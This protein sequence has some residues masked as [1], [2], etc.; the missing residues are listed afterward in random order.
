[1]KYSLPLLSLLLAGLGGA[2]S[3]APAQSSRAQLQDHY[4]VQLRRDADPLRAAQRHGVG[5]TFLYSR[6]INGFA[7]KIPPGILR[8][9]QRDPQVIA[10]IPDRFISAIGF[11]AGKPGGGGSGTTGQVVPPGITRVGAA[12]ANNLGFTG[13]GIGVAIVDT[14]IDL[15]HPDLRIS[16]V[17]FSA[18][19]GSATDD[20]GHGTHVAGTVGALNNNIGVVGVAPGVTLYSVK[21]VDYLTESADSLILA[22]L[23]WLASNAAT[24]SPPIR[25]VNM[26]IARNGSVSDNP[27]LHAAVQT[28]VNQGITIVVAAGNESTMTVS[29]QIPAT[30]PEVLAIASTTAS[31][32]PRNKKT[33]L[34]VPRDSASFFT[35]DGALDPFTGIGVTV[36]APGNEQETISNTGTF[37]SLGVL[38]TAWSGWGGNTDRISGTSMASP[39][40]AGVVALLWEQALARGT[41]LAP[42]DARRRIRAGAQL[43]NT[44]PLN[45]LSSTYT[46]DGEREGILSAPGALAAP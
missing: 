8:R 46:F 39:H 19:G 2:P 43:R 9:L 1:M 31:D 27:L 38:S 24:V 18:W 32:G 26:S 29:Q 40:V 34:F 28:L 42:E 25:V 13:A 7:G 33:K 17:T 15:A 21:V 23:D 3:N 14:G 41:T 37:S 22:G 12:P 44:A 45:S 5:P 16:P 11:T 6:A 20:N 30:Y 4:L 36:S 10:I 35:T